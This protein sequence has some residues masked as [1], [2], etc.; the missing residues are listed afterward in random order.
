MRETVCHVR[1]TADDRVDPQVIAEHI[2]VWAESITGVTR[3]GVLTDEPRPQHRYWCAVQAF[4][5]PSA[6]QGPGWWKTD[7]E[8][9]LGL[10]HWT[11][12]K[13]EE[14]ARTWLG[15]YFDSVKSD[16]DDDMAVPVGPVR[17]LVWE[18][19]AAGTDNEAACVLRWN[20]NWWGHPA[21]V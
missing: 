7:P 4:T 12:D 17:V 20:P 14:V 19:D 1:V 3:V 5:E 9:T 6:E 10:D 13:P 8:W 2:K 21:G 16:A 15:N 11:A 18:G